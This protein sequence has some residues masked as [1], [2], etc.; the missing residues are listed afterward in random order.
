M[1][2]AE[3]ML[4]KHGWDPEKGLGKNNQGMKTALKPVLKFDTRGVGC[5]QKDEYSSEFKWW[6]YTYNRAAKKVSDSLD[7]PEGEEKKEK[8]RKHKEDDEEKST[9]K[10][11]YTRFQKSSVLMDNKEESVQLEKELAVAETN[12][13]TPSD[14]D[15]LR[16]CGGRTAHKGARHGIKMGG[17]LQRLQEQEDR[18][19]S[20]SCDNSLEKKK[21]KKRKSIEQ[22]DE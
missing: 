1:E 7:Q 6:E 9:K 14:E 2:F 13:P 5:N 11:I 19:L 18:A 10:S 4:K 22:I 20:S 15:L 21:K 17:K 12:T 3:R 16:I 8:K